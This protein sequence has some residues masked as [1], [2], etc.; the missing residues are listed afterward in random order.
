MWITR[1][2]TYFLWCPY[3]VV[4][5][6]AIQ[7]VLIFSISTDQVVNRRNSNVLDIVVYRKNKYTEKENYVVFKYFT[8]Y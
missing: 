2:K 4:F 6:L 7:Y 3:I 1:V 5:V 8:V